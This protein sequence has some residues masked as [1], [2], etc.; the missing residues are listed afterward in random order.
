MTIEPTRAPGMPVPT[1][2]VAAPPRRVWVLNGVNLGRLGRREPGIYG[3]TSHESLTASLISLGDEMGLAV[4]VRQTD[5]ESVMIG[6]LH[7]AADH[8]IPVVLNPAAWTH[9]SI[10]LRDAV[11]QRT[12]DLIE[13]HISNVH[14]R[15]EFRH[16]SVISAVA[17]GVIAGLG[18]EG[19][20]AALRYIAARPN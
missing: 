14:T 18:V 8:A 12:A 2:P 11:A 15:E 13:V 7:E 19:Y 3:V 5:E 1:E 20:A 9:Y 4:D 10:A 16:R 6:W 17:T